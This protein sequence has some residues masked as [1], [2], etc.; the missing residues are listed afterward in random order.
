MVSERDILDT[1]RNVP[2]SEIVEMSSL[3]KNNNDTL[4]KPFVWK[5]LNKRDFNI[6]S[7]S[8]SDYILIYNIGKELKKEGH[9]N[10]NM[11]DIFKS[12][13]IH[14]N[15]EVTKLL[16]DNDNVN[17]AY[18]NSFAFMFALDEGYTDIVK[19]LLQDPRIDPNTGDNFGISV[20]AEN[21]YIDIVKLLLKDGRIDPSDHNNNAIINAAA[22]GH[23]N[24]V[25]LLLQDE[26]VNPSDNNNE[27]IKL[28]KSN[29]HQDVVDILMM[30]DRVVSTYESDDEY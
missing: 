29:G 27:A 12:A 14:G 22:N 18:D 21:G 1:I 20:A 8:K 5:F 17:P 16:I 10:V 15:K 13:I 6:D 28:A 3:S 24:V 9:K 7:S 4:N 11:Q 26:R 2:F 30:D 19:L 25:K 23:V